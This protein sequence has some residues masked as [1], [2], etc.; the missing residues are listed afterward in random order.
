MVM[1]VI[2]ETNE[3]QPVYQAYRPPNTAVEMPTVKTPSED[4][5]NQLGR[6]V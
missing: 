5:D 6:Q 3:T 4:V 1:P 2:N